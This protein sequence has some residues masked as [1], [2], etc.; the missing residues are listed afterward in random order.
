MLT[1]LAASARVERAAVA[2]LAARTRIDTRTT[3]ALLAFV[4]GIAADQALEDAALRMSQRLVYGP[5]GPTPSEIANLRLEAALG[6]RITLFYLLA[7]LLAIPLAEERH[8][9][10]GIDPSISRATWTDLAMWCHY[11]RRRDGR[12]GITREML[13][14]SQQ[15]LNGRLFRV[16]SLQFELKGFTG[17]LRAYRH[18]TNGELMLVALPGVNFSHGG[19]L[20][21]R[22]PGPGT[23][24]ADGMLGPGIVFGHRIDPIQGTVGEATVLLTP[25]TWEPALCEGDPMLLVHIPND[26][27]LSVPDFLRSAGDAIELFAMLEPKVKPKGAFGEAWL[28]DPQVRPFLPDPSGVDALSAIVSLYPCRISEASTLQRLFGP[29]ATRDSVIGSPRAGLNAVQRA[30]ADFLSEPANA[31]CARGAFILNDRLMRLIDAAR[32]GTK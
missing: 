4:A 30:M 7:A 5:P 28:L 21:A 27:R 32:Q 3:A 20:I 18:R 12:L 10:R 13:A 24:A 1:Q 14:W 15:G 9:A 8:R 29:S 31:L 2:E 6:S 26:A 19:R 25:D 23:W 22:E 17:P 16:G 11:L